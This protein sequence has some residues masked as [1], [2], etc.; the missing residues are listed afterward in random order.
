M[1]RQ[2]IKQTVGQAPYF[3]SFER[4]PVLIM[5]VEAWRTKMRR[6]PLA[7]SLLFIASAFGQSQDNTPSP[8]NPP[9]THQPHI[10]TWIPP[11]HPSPP[12]G[13]MIRKTVLVVR[14]TCKGKDGTVWS[15][16]GT[17]FI[18]AYHDPRLA[19][20]SMFDYLVT[21]R[22]VAECFDDDLQPREVL[23]VGLEVNL[24]DGQTSTLSLSDH[25]NA[26]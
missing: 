18:V 20:D 16:S 15:S 17:G 14:E 22:H 26:P 1:A 11:D 8:P 19:A 2:I 9:P 5:D 23:S 21:N 10:M 7:I 12:F 6:S 25:G 4:L 13:S 24:K 3:A